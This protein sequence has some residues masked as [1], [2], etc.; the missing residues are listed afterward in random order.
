MCWE[1]EIVLC[2]QITMVYGYLSSIS[3]CCVGSHLMKIST[4]LVALIISKISLD[5]VIINC[6]PELSDIVS[7]IFQDSLIVLVL[8]PPH[9][10]IG[11]AKFL[12]SPIIEWMH[13][14]IRLLLLQGN[15]ECRMML[16]S[17]KHSTCSMPSCP[18]IRYAT[19]A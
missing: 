19:F 13:Y 12:P 17:S 5:V 14:Q 4:Q 2:F 15:L 1:M 3:F 11:G 18:Q 16:W 9:N 6:L 8:F 7:S 10:L